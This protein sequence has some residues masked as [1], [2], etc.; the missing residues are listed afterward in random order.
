MDPAGKRQ[1]QWF[2]AE[3][4]RPVKQGRF[5][6]NPTPTQV[7]EERERGL[8][9]DLNSREPSIARSVLDQNASR[10]R[11]PSPVRPNFAS[12]SHTWALPNTIQARRAN[13]WKEYLFLLF[14]KQGG[15][16]TLACERSTKSVDSRAF[17]IVETPIRGKESHL[18]K[19]GSMRS[20]S[21][22]D[23][24][25]VYEWNDHLFTV[26]EYIP[27][28]LREIILSQRQLDEAQVACLAHQV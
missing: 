1:T 4:T 25:E 7:T 5:P 9:R 19:L 3:I 24:L 17:A 23:I 8:G 22:L 15:L 2:G 21:F 28:S 10:G 26:A 14:V 27:T 11:V 16:A 12:G 13:P 6:V 20:P 18:S